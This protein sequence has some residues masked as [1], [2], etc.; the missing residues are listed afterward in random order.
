MPILPR[1][2][3]ARVARHRKSWFSSSV[4][5]SLNALTLQPWGFKPDMTCLIVPSFPAASM[6]WRTTRIAQRSCAKS[7]SCKSHRRAIPC[8]SVSC[9]CSLDFNPSVSAGSKSFNRKLAPSATRNGFAY[10]FGFICAICLSA[11]DRSQN[12]QRCL[13][14]SSTQARSLHFPPYFVS[15]FHHQFALAPLFIDGKQ[16]PGGYG[17]KPALRAERQ[18]FKWHI[19]GRFV[20]VPPQLVL[21]FHPGFLRRYQSQDNALTARNQA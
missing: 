1:S 4:E 16:I 14:G 3:R 6:A 21:R 11:Q 9:A 12:H 15:G 20:D 5:G 17:C 19:L 18:I 7:F 13:A 8:S 10:L 2:G